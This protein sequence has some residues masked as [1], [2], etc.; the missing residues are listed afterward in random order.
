M[1]SGLGQEYEQ[2]YPAM[3]TLE[4]RKS[5]LPLVQRHAAFLKAAGTTAKEL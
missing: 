3:R 2:V 4:R 1:R 5:F